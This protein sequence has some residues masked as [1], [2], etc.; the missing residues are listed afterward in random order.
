MSLRREVACLDFD[1]FAENRA[2]EVLEFLYLLLGALV[3][4]LYH[5]LNEL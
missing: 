4:L 3:L 5:T 2:M 1:L